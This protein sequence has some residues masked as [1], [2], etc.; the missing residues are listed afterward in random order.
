MPIHSTSIS[1]L[2]HKRVITN[3][4]KK[5]IINNIFSGGGVYPIGVI[6][7]DGQVELYT[8]D[9]YLIVGNITDHIS[10]MEDDD[11]AKLRQAINQLFFDFDIIWI[12][13]HNFFASFSRIWDEIDQ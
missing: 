2:I 13:N 7:D 1:S 4:G 12:S 9:G 6:F 11:D 8:N 10:L 5:G 3:N